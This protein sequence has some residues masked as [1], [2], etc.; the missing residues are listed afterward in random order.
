M[1]DPPMR[2]V[3]HVEDP[4]VFHRQIALFGQ[5][6]VKPDGWLYFEI[7]AAY[8]KETVGLLTAMQYRDVVCIRDIS[9]KDRMIKARR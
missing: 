1:Y 2:V 4:C 5:Q 6:K 8:G 7:N 9:G 3:I